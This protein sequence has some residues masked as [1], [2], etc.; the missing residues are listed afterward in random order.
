M[1]DAKLPIALVFAMAVQLGAVAW[2]I[3]GMVHKIEH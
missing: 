1:G 2:Y 3:G